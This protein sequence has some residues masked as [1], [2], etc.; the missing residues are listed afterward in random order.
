MTQKETPIATLS[1]EELHALNKLE[2]ELGVTLVAYESASSS[3]K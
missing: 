3:N 1:T 2:N